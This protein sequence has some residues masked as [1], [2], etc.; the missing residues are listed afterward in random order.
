[1]D[2]P[3]HRLLQTKVS[4]HEGCHPFPALGAIAQRRDRVR[5]QGTVVDLLGQNPMHH[6][7]FLRDSSTPLVHLRPLTS[8]ALGGWLRLLGAAFLG[9]TELL[10][11]RSQ[12]TAGFHEAPTT[13][14][15][16]E[17]L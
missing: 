13:C 14:V 2:R 11:A 7:D 6:G 17:A 10:F 16:L 8:A 12:R 4:E 9:R 15:R 1:M 3:G 5:W